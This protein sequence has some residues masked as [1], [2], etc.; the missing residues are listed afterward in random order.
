MTSRNSEPGTGDVLREPIGA[1]LV[2]A[3]KIRP[4][5]GER[6]LRHAR[7]NGLRFGDAAV[8]LGFVSADD[9]ADMLARQFRYP[10][11]RLGESS[12]SPDVVAAWTPFTPSV[13]ALRSLRSQLLLRWFGGGERRSLA[14]V[15]P[16]RSEGRSHLAA[17]LAVVFSQ[18]GE[19]TLLIDAD[20]RN[21]RQH[22]LFGAS[23][24]TGLSAVLAGRSELDVIARIP[25]FVDL[26]I[27]SAGAIPPN[28][29]ELLGRDV[30][31]ELIGDVSARFDVVIVD[32]PAASL[33][34][35]AQLVAARCSGALMLVRK[36]HSLLDRC[37]DLAD[38][39]SASGVRLVGSVVNEG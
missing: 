14:I 35:D 3:G 11:L 18:M 1:M 34:A 21:P 27:L 33:G 17:N 31:P 38:A 7:D 9:V 4:E 24:A 2:D 22:T 20:L 36:D 16:G 39:L 25:G 13:E 37:R 26:S 6:V 23:N 28:P 15:G 5:D 19:R 10:Y 8:A 29:L 12:V 30:F 32:T